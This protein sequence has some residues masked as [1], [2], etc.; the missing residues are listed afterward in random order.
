MP[1]PLEVQTL[2]NYAN[3]QPLTTQTLKGDCRVLWL[4]SRSSGCGAREDLPRDHRA[5]RALP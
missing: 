1:A 3:L 4:F 2:S 5:A